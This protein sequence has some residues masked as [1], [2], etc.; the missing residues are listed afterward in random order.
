[1]VKKMLPSNGRRIKAYSTSLTRSS[2][3]NMLVSNYI[4]CLMSDIY[5]IVP[6]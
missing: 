6:A 1:M 2:L 4:I 5:I 3:K